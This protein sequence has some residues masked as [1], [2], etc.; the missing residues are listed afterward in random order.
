MKFG[1]KHLLKTTP[2][3]LKRLGNSLLAVS[4]FVAAYA[5]YNE[6]KWV[7]IMGLISGIIGTLLCNM[8]T[9]EV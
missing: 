6:E 7:A 9:E 5:F 2:K 4:T 1:L 3:V 8:F